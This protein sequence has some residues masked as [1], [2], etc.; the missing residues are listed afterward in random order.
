MKGVILDK[1]QTSYTILTEEG[2]YISKKLKT[3]HD[4]GEEVNINTTFLHYKS[5]AAAAALMILIGVL[6]FN[7]LMMPYGYAEVAINPSVEL[8]YNKLYKVISVEGLN[9]DGHK[10]VDKDEK[11]KG[12]KVED[13]V[14]F[15]IQEADRDGYL[16]KI[17]DNYIVIA[18]TNKK[19]E[20]N[21]ELEA[22]F[23][24]KVKNSGAELTLMNVEKNKYE[25][26]RDKKDNPAVEGLKEKLTERNIPEEKFQNV[27]E[28][29][30]LAR[31]LKNSE[32]EK[33]GKPETAG[34][35]EHVN[36]PGQDKD[37]K[38]KEEKN[39]AEDMEKPKDIDSR[40]QEEDQNNDDKEKNKT[41]L[42]ED[43]GEGSE[44]S[45]NSED[46]GNSGDT[47]KANNGNSGKGSNNSGGN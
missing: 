27:E 22:K 37:D 14:E 15:L 21:S 16:S 43:S 20:N 13:A 17:K 40:E 26:I 10:L 31:M 34:P 38:G 23:K 24:E 7:M 3:S 42:N 32:K 6:V 5:F 12:M 44:N 36:P 11:I 41:E 47:G 1:K 9:N 4:L 45:G 33:N 46:S 35:P 28:V 19:D 39:K 8:G 18:Y 25:E 2:D 29:K 30:E